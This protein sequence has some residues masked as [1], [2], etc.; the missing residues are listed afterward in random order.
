MPRRLHI[1]VDIDDVVMNF[2]SDLVKSINL[3]YGTVIDPEETPN[4]DDN[5]VKKLAV[6]GP[7][8]TWWEWLQERDWIWHTF[9]P[10]PGAIGGIDL[11]RRQGHYVEALTAKPEWA[12]WTVWK[13]L[14]KWRPAFHRVTIVPPDESKSAHS[15]ARVLIDDRDKNIRE[16]VDSD[17]SRIGVLFKRPWSN[18]ESFWQEARVLEVND[19]QG[20]HT[21]MEA[22]QDGRV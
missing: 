8:R 7:G 18:A 17:P 14:G 21:M 12:E 20:V 6:F 1:A 9:Q 19:W 15:D 10:V 4:W 22:I 2:W 5:A 3:E 13:W 16:W 11:L